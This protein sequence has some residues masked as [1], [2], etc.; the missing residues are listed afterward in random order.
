MHAHSWVVYAKSPL[1]GPAAV[2]GYLGR[3]AHRAAPTS[4]RLVSMDEHAVR[5]R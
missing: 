2:L 5:F 1:A 4:E 3:Y